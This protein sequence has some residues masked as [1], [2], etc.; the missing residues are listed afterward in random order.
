M[1]TYLPHPDRYASIP[2]TRCGRSGLLL[3]RLSLGLWHNFGGTDPL[4]N[5][6]SLTGQELVNVSPRS[7][8]V[9]V[10]IKMDATTRAHR[11][12]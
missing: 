7:Q 12:V 3:P 9:S 1:S 6:R 11:Y 4:E 5:Q 8:S 2:Y 10:S